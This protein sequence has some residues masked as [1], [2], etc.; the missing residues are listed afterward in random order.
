[1]DVTGRP[2][3]GEGRMPG[4]ESRVVVDGETIAGNEGET[5]GLEFPELRLRKDIGCVV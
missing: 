3:R 5:D 4:D 1:M 2:S